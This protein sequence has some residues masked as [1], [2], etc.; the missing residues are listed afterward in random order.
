MASWQHPSSPPGFCCATGRVGPRA[1][2]RRF[3]V[4]PRKRLATAVLELDGVVK[5]YRGASEEVHAVDG[6]SLSLKAGE[7]VAVHGPSG[8]GKT[9][10]LL[11]V[12]ALL[13]PDSGSIRFEER[14]LASLSEQQISEYQLKDV[15]FIYQRFRLMAKAS[16]LE[17]ASRKLLV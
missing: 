12:A 6:L 16:A 17:N 4:D 13:W 8:S 2:E 14:D 15:G 5:H 11:M 3:V 7:M 10:L 1:R 9:T